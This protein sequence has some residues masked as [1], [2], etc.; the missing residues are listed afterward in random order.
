MSLFPTEHLSVS[1]TPSAIGFARY[2][3]R[4]RPALAE[5]FEIPVEVCSLDGMLEALAISLKE[6]AKASSSIRFNVSNHFCRVALLPWTEERLSGL[7]QRVLLSRQFSELYGDMEGWEIRCNSAPT[8]RQS[9]IAVAIPERL[10][11]TIRDLSKAIGLECRSISAHAI[12]SWNHNR[13][14]IRGD[15]LFTVIEPGSAFVMTLRAVDASNEMASVR[16]VSLPSQLSTG[17]IESL[18]DRELLLQGVANASNVTCDTLGIRLEGHSKYTVLPYS[19]ET[20]SPVKA[21]A[22]NGAGI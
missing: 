3:G 15:G 21:M 13:H 17:I 19:F 2:Q 9:S 14:Q 20:I 5:Q 6:K 1:L 10:L 16:L 7:E 12:D 4:W 8:Y 22:V 18:I 11:C